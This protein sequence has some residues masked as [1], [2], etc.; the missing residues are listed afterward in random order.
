M[1]AGVVEEVE[2]V[3]LNGLGSGVSIRNA[4]TKSV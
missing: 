2:S 4:I 1:D 3:R